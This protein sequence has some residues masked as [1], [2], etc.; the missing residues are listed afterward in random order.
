MG[1][2]KV[3]R[4]I[5]IPDPLEQMVREAIESEDP[6]RITEAENRVIV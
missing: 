6:E 2:P 5:D 1:N 4:T 3:Q